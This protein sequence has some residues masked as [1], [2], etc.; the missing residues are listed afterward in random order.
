MSTPTIASDVI[1]LRVMT[2]PNFTTSKKRI[3]LLLIE[4]FRR[5]INPQNYGH[6]DH[7]QVAFYYL[8]GFVRI[9]RFGESGDLK[10][11]WEEL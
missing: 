6:L 4:T 7:L 9:L 3:G 8:S 2:F 1:M 5:L 10:T 11:M